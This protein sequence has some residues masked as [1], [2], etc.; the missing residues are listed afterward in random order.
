MSNYLLVHGSFGSPFGNWL[1][2]LRSEIEKRGLIV[3]TPDFPTGVGYQNYKNWER[4]LESYVSAKLINENTVIYAHS[5]API[6][7]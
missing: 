6:F 7:R 2:Y 3:Y 5:I 4:V 1:P